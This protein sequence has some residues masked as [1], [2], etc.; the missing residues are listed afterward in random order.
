MIDDT[1]TTETVTDN[2]TNAVA[3]ASNKAGILAVSYGR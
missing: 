3:R 1:I 2:T